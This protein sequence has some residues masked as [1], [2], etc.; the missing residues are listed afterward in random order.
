MVGTAQERPTSGAARALFDSLLRLFNERDVA[1]IP[2]L[3][4][5]DVEYR[6]DAWPEP[7]TSHAG[8]ERLFTAL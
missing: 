5:E 2:T 3:Y 1:A 7:V 6:D 8:V 4:A